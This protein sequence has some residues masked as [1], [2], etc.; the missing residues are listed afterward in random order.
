MLAFVIPTRDRHEELARTIARIDA[1]GLENAEIIVADNASRQAVTLPTQ[2][3]RG[4]PIRLLRRERNEAAAAR[5]ACALATDPR[6]EWLVML[7]DDSHPLDDGLSEVLAAQPASVAAVAARITLPDGRHEAGGLPEV[8]IGCGVAIRRTPFLELGGYDPS[9][10]YYAEEYDLAA[11]LIHA[12]YRIAF[13]E[14]FRI[15]HRKVQ[16]GRDFGRILRR[17][18]RN[19]AVVAA[20][21]APAPARASELAETL[22]RYARI[23]IKERALCGYVRGLADLCLRLPRQTRTPLTA[24][25]FD[26]FTGLAAAREALAFAHSCRPLG[27]TMLIDRGKNARVIEQALR[28]LGVALTTVEAKAE[29]LV[30]GTL[31]PGP[32]ADAL[33]R[34]ADLGRRVVAPW[35]SCVR[36][37]VRSAAA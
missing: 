29:T 1:L 30:I 15:E 10:E 31:S 23:A 19:N 28:E 14:R 35:R 16:A 11:R 8:F 22:L 17:L 4:T 32:M 20:R 6:C 9:F 36:P 26:R 34:R 3:P 37:L 2:T 5:N 13:D 21:H 25:E 18:V 27:P 33:L 12:G 7:D 24:E